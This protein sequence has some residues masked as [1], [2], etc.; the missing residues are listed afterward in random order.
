MSAFQQASRLPHPVRIT[1]QVWPEGTVPVVSVFCITYNH[2][3]FVR[4]AIEGFLM[5]ETTF[6][7]Q[8]FIHD[9]ASTDETAA[10][11]KEYAET[12][13]QLFWTVLQTENQWSK[14]NKKILFEYLGQQRGEF[15][16]LCEGD[17]YW[18]SPDKL[19]NQVATLDKNLEASGCYHMAGVLSA[20][21]EIHKVI[22]PPEMRQDRVMADAFRNFWVPTCSLLYR[23]G[24]R[25]AD[26]LWAAHLPMGDVP[27]FAELCD[28]GPLVF[29]P[30]QWS[31]YR[32]HSGGIWSGR[33]RIKQLEDML[34]LQ[35]AVHK[36]FGRRCTKRL[37]QS[38]KNLKASLF[39]VLVEEKR[40]WRATKYLLAYLFSLPITGSLLKTQKRNIVAY[41]SLL[42]RPSKRADED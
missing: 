29:I 8:I 4:D 11:I 6:P 38:I 37:P 5:Q 16:A 35:N 13:P 26:M 39:G 14:G 31:V 42:A 30:K 24:A 19:Q 10:I 1:E 9:D 12:Y 28:Y 15:I 21:G 2:E 17:D 3:K 32:I 40:K 23:R 36:R 22:P 7:V 27:L 33:S 25:P 18:T 41:I 20:D 34:A